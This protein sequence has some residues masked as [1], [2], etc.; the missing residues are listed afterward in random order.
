ME[1]LVIGCGVSGL[2]T[3]IRLQEAGWR[4]RIWTRALP[5]ETTSSIAAAIWYPYKA[6]PEAQVIAWGRSAYAEFAAL[7]H[8]PTTGVILR[9][10]FELWRRSAPDPWWRE[11]VP[12][13]RRCVTDELPSGLHDGF[14]FTVPVIEMPMYLP[15][16][17]A[18]FTANGG[19]VEQR[20]VSS[21]AE[22]T[23]VC[24]VVVNCT[25]LDARNLVGDTLLYPIRGQIVR[26]SNPGLQRALLDQADTEHMTYIVP[27][28]HDCIVGGTSHDGQWDTTPDPATAEAILR[29][30]I[31]LE[32]R[33]AQAE[34]LEHKVGLRPA[35]PTIRLEREALA[36]GA[37]CI[38]NYGHGG[39]GVT[40][41]WG[42][43]AEVVKL[44][45]QE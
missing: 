43:A 42:C 32:P 2:S 10:T 44:A 38:H 41:S 16:L 31:A 24:A 36:H 15:Y 12:H 13:V 26:V 14:A 22:A 30:A 21:L 8:D 18:R 5:H 9:E 6:Y 17:L 37:C 35:R 40:L 7:A 33:L 25:G 39:A 34:I 1:A 45:S 11:A 27:R 29:R 23:A 4:V 28:V 19:N 20:V 3:A